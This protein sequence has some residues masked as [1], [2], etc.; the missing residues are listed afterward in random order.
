MQ[1]HNESSRFKLENCDM[2]L[3]VLTVCTCVC[4]FSCTC[5]YVSGQVIQCVMVHVC[6][7]IIHFIIY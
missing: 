7:I 2:C 4:V 3:R 1:I 6:D 5:A